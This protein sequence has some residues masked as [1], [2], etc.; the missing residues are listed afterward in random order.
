[1]AV[2]EVEMGGVVVSEVSEDWIAFALI[3]DC[4]MILCISNFLSVGENFLFLLNCGGRL[5]LPPNDLCFMG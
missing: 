1:M 3:E 5:L 4:L 2:G